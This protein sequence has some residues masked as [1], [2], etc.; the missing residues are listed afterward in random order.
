MFLGS[1]TSP[2]IAV[3][4]PE[5]AMHALTVPGAKPTGYGLGRAGWCT[6][7]VGTEEAPLDLLIDWTEE[8]YRTIAP[9]RLVRQLDDIVG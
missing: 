6:I 4:L 8:S 7:P 3:K 1:V 2:S 5:S 9:K